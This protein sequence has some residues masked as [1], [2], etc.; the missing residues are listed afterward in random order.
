[1]RKSGNKTTNFDPLLKRTI[2][3][4]NS[5][6]FLEYLKRLLVLNLLPD[7]ELGSGGV[8]RSTK[9]GY[10]NIHA[11]FTFHPQPKLAQRVN[12]LIYLN[13][14]WKNLEAIRILG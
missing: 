4:L 11:D 2:E 9:E 6:E 7:H 14:V 12:V 10:L 13:D 8:H 5:E 1:M 3:A